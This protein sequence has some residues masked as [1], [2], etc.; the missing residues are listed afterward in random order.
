MQGLR[1]LITGGEPLIHSKFKKINEMLPEFSIRKVLFTNG[2][3]LNREI[4]KQLNVQEVQISIDGL[5]KAHDSLRGNGTF[6]LALNAVKRAVDSGFEVS[7]STMIHS[8]NLG[9][10]DGMERLFKSIGIKDW[11]VDIPC[12]TGRLKEHSEFQLSPEQSGKYLGYGYGNGL[13]A[14]MSGFACG[15]NL[16]AVMADG[17]VSK[18]S[19]YADTPVGRI[20]EGLRECWQR[21]KPIKLS[22]LKCNCEYVEICRGG[23]RY[24]ARQL[25]DPYGKDLYK[26]YFYDIV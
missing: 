2:L 24:R 23:C 5:E 7:I 16:M 4:L 17:K 11:T 1:V 26:C 8:K 19:F 10:F 6:R 9:D 25:G 15:L 20:E 18:C 22:K 12:V 14:G 3:L 13:H 21:I